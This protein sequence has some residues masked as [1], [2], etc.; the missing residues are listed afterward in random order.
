MEKIIWNNSFSVGVQELD[1]QHKKLINLI[2]NLIEMKDAKVDSEI[3]S[4]ALTE[5]TKYTLEHFEAEEKLMNENNYPDYSLHKGQHMQFKKQTAKFCMDTMSYK[6]T[7]PI[8]ILTFL[9]EWLINHI[10]DSDMQYK[11]F[12]SQSGI[13]M[14]I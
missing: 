14:N 2:N 8:E 3:I 12:F 1:K 13:K 10:L 7:I 6:S 5:M 9:K 11:T 4:D